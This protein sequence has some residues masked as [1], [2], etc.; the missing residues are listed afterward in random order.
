V[1][2][3]QLRNLVK[4]LAKK[5]HKVC[6][7]IVGDLLRSMDNSLQANSKTREGANH[8]VATSTRRS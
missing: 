1:D 6:P 7:T 5:E 3:P 2:L 8:I 4:E